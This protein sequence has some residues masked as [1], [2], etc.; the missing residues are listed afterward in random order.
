MARCRRLRIRLRHYFTVRF[1]ILHYHLLKNAGST[2]EEL[3]SWNF[4]GRYRRFDTE[5]RDYA[6]SNAELMRFLNANPQLEAVSSHQ[7]YDPVPLERGYVFFDLCFLRDPLERIRS[8]YDFFRGKP[9]PGDPISDLANRATLGEYVGEL[10][11]NYPWTVNDAQTNQLANGLI[12]DP[13]KGEQDLER[14]ARR[15]LNTSLLGVVDRFAESVVTMQHAMRMYFPHFKRPHP[16]VNVSRGMSGTAEERRARFR[17]ECGERIFC[18]LLRLNQLDQ[19]LVR[20]AREEVARRFHMVED[21]EERVRA[22]EAGTAFIHS[23]APM[24]TAELQRGGNRNK[25]GRFAILKLLARFPSPA[26]FDADYYRRNNPDIPPGA[27]PRVHFLTRGALQGRNPHPF[28]DIEFFAR[29]GRPHPLF[30]AEFYLRKNPDVRVAGVN[31]LVHYVLH[32]AAELRKPHP[33]FDPK[34]YVAQCPEALPNPLAHFLENCAGNPHPLFDCESYMREHPTGGG[35]PLVH[36]VVNATRDHPL[37]PAAPLVLEIDDVELP[38]QLVRGES[39]AVW[40]D[41]DGRTE[42]NAPAHMRPFFLPLR[43]P[44]IHAQLR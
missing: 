37:T 7:L 8:T 11:E 44:Q 41:E 22:F 40:Q 9:A 21:G 4:A 10:I 2:M 42:F 25:P 12:N 14:A 18:E 43:Y 36:W 23:P 27:N 16:P 29:T 5:D 20:Q 30:D 32:G 28:V 31:P 33:W 35:N 19:E 17:E 15:M 39:A 1:I 34:Y 38:I 13:P 6:I 3:L 24:L 26:L